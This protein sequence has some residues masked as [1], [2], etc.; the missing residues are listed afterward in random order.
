MKHYI[1]DFEK[2]NKTGK[3][4]ALMELTDSQISYPR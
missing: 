1:C 2:A 4:T 3:V